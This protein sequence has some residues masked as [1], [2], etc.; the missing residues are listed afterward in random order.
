MSSSLGIMAE[1]RLY[2]STICRLCAEDN[3]NGELLYMGDGDDPDL[4]SMVNRYL[5]L[6]IHD[7]GKLP[8]TICP[9]C[10]IQLEATIQFLNYWWMVKGKFVRCGNIR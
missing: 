9:G 10:N 5:P 6:K 3:G 4:S 2:D 7:D 8:R 1:V